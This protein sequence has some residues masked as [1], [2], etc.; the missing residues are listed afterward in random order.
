MSKTDWIWKTDWTSS[1]DLNYYRDL[2]LLW[3]FLF[4]SILFADHITTSGSGEKRHAL[5]FLVIALVCL[6]LAKEWPFL[7]LGSLGFVTFRFWVFASGRSLELWLTR[8]GLLAATLLVLW[9]FRNRRFSYR[10]PPGLSVLDL[11]VG[12]GSLLLAGWLFIKLT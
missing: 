4:S 8:I 2:A 10:F 9:A 5:V 11:V 1:R 7:L 6:L 12:V 3:P